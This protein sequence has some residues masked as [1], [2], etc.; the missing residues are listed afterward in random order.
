METWAWIAIGL[1][2]GLWVAAALL[3]AAGFLGDVLRTTRD[4][5]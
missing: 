1:M 5:D 2:G 4:S 3:F